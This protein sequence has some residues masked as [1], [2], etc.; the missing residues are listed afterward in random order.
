MLLVLHIFANY[1]RY[2]LTGRGYLISF[3]SPGFQD[4]LGRRFTKSGSA[5]VVALVQPLFFSTL[6]ASASRS[7][8]DE[9]EHSPRGVEASM[10]ASSPPLAEVN[11]NNLRRKASRERLPSSGDP[12]TNG[13]END[14][15]M[16]ASSR[17]PLLGGKEL[18][19]RVPKLDDAVLASHGV[20]AVNGLDG[21]KTENE[22][23]TVKSEAGTSAGG[24]SGSRRKRNGNTKPPPKRKSDSDD[25]V[26]IEDDD[27]IQFHFTPFSP[28]FIISIL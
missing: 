19:I 25:D 27:G 12:V 17:S 6:G 10:D 3:L 20:S 13:E 28:I 15:P 26:S 2:Y 7:T 22:V 9:E 4:S 23:K 14:A 1:A 16:S 24:P 5:A 18:Q 21:L 8:A 11:S